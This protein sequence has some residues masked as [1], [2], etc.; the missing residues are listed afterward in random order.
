M[1]L[2]TL[3]LLRTGIRFQDYNAKQLSVAEME[4]HT[5]I[6]LKHDKGRETFLSCRS[7][8]AQT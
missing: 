3:N 8:A 4:S 6:M 5:C 2:N 1:F 7:T